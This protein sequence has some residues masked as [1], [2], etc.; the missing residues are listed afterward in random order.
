MFCCC[1]HIAHSRTCKYF[2]RPLKPILLLERSTQDRDNSASAAALIKFQRC[3]LQLSWTV[4]TSL[5][6]I[7]LLRQ[8]PN[9]G[10]TTSSIKQDLPASR[11]RYRQFLGKVI[12]PRY[13]IYAVLIHHARQLGIHHLEETRREEMSYMSVAISWNYWGWKGH[14]ESILCNHLTW[15]GSARTGCPGPC[16][17]G[18]ESA[19]CTG[20]PQLSGYPVSMPDYL[21]IDLLSSGGIK[22]VSNFACSLLSWEESGSLSF[23]PS[24]SSWK[25]HFI[26]LDL[27]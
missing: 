14:L 25:R 21:K 5:L 7:P 3:K 23:I 10:T 16:W 26:S 15:A 9:W 6:V 11:L 1:Q 12:K 8:I 20:I 18:A 17:A 13:V 24:L 19:P 22:C 2:L 27:S 4:C